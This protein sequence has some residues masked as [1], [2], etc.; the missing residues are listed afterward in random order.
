VSWVRVGSQFALGVALVLVSLY[1]LYVLSSVVVTVLIAII[2]AQAISPLVIRIRRL[3]A[4]RAQAVMMVYALL[5]VVVLALGWLMEQALTT[6]MGNLLS[7]LPMIQYRIYQ[8][9]VQVPWRPIR[10]G[11]LQ[12]LGQV[13]E[14]S[15]AVPAEVPFRLLET[16]RV[17]AE[18]VVRAFSVLI[19]AFFWIAERLTI[20]GVLVRLLA[21]EH[22]ERAIHIWDDVEDKLGA[23]VRA[24][25]ILMAC[26]G[27]AF[28][29]G[30]TLLGVKYAVLLA[31]FAA[32]M[33]AVPLIGPVAGTAPAVLVAL[34]QSPELALGAAGIGIA[35]HVIEGNFLFPRIMRHTTGVSPLAVVLGILIGGKLMGPPGALLAVPVAAGLQV[36]LTDLGVLEDRHSPSTGPLQAIPDEE[37]TAWEASL[38]PRE[39]A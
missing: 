30:L 13:N 32:L 16:G 8:S 6:E 11:L 21:L 33:Q 29:V 35:A 1:L 31:V 14:P 5:A 2:F 23:W 26:I 37:A 22:R 15:L 18:V 36:L 17:V 38:E 10:E 28:A 25:L 3:G 39:V 12:L 9:I 7:A 4:R 34:T 20:R 24:E 19:I 27:V